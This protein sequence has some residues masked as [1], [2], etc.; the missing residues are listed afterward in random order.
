MCNFP[1]HLLTPLQDQNAQFTAGQDAKLREM[2]AEGKTW[3]DIHAEIPEHGLSALK[4]RFKDINKDGNDNAGAEAKKL[5]GTKK[6]GGGKK[7]DNEK[8]AD[9]DGGKGEEKKDENKK[10]ENKQGGGKKGSGEKEEPSKAGSKGSAKFGMKDMITLQ[11]DD[12]FN[13]EELRILAGMVVND[14]SNRW[15][16]IAS[17]FFDKTGRRVSA[18]DIREKFEEMVRMKG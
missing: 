9:G 4:A 3:K 1:G 7:G 17:R 13:F 2:K 10:G 11:E 12:M 5:E 8:K 14:E 18:D 15:L 6:D 16:R